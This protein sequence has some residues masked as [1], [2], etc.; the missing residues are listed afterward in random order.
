MTRT[1]SL[2]AAL[3]VAAFLLTSCWLR[4][5]PVPVEPNDTAMCAAACENLRRVGCPEGDPVDG[6]SC[7]QDCVGIQES[8]HA[9]NP[10]C[11]AGIADCI[12]LRSCQLNRKGGN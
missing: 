2:L 8:G 10:T 6:I 1:T 11:V 12:Q 7:E 9:M 5:P 4:P 3:V